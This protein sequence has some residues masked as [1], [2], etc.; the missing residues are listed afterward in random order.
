MVVLLVHIHIIGIQS[1]YKLKQ[2]Q[3][4][5]LL[6]HIVLLLKMVLVRQLLVLFV[7]KP[8]QLNLSEINL[9][10]DGGGVAPYF[11]EISNQQNEIVKLQLDSGIYTIAI[12]DKMVVLKTIN[13]IK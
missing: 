7:G 13:R 2:L 5:Y 9:S 8:S 12:K 11:C 3:L 10:I 1:L 6:A 4:I